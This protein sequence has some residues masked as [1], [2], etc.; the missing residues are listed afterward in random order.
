V[1]AV[2]GVAAAA[3]RAA[4]AIIR[5]HAGAID[6]DKTKASYQDLVTEADRAAQA[7]IEAAI[8]ASF[9]T[10]AVL[11]EESVPPGAAASA[12][13][14]AEKLAAAAAGAPTPWL[15]VIDPID[16][17][18]NFVHGVPCSVVSIGVSHGGVLVAGVVYEPYRDELFAAA[19]GRGATLNGRPIAVAA[20]PALS[21]ALIGY[22]LHHTHHVGGAMVRGLDAVM[23]VSRGCRSLGSAALHLAYVAAGR[24]TAF[25][26]LD[27]SS[28]D[29]AAGALLVTEAGGRVTDTR[30]GRYTLATRDVLASNGAPGVHDGVLETLARVGADV[31]PPAPA[32]PPPA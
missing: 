8:A 1:D 30:G 26:E 14:L 19:A 21:R 31:A 5:R 20:E 29:I 2:L 7:A 9:P 12:A 10:H 23:R 22:G 16:G 25:W 32:P 4:G 6:V 13:A 3:A 11:G 15:W 24:L 27:L 18:T 28:W 17:T